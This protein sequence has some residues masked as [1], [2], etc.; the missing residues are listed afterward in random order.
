MGIILASKSPRRQTLL[1]LIGIKDFTVM[2]SSKDEVAVPG[3]PPEK[4][5]ISLALQK[6]ADGSAAHPCDI[7]IS[8]DTLVF[9]DGRPLGK[10]RDENDARHMLKALSGRTHSVYT[11]VFVSLGGRTITG[12]FFN[13]VGL[14]LCRLSLMLAEFGV[15]II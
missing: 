14:P 7:V 10:P 8:A 11:G 6:G 13:I 15:N 2:P 9:L 5:V 1:D 12:A 3:L 4:T